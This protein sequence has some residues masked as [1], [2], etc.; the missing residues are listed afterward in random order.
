M[1]NILSSAL[2]T[3]AALTLATMLVACGGDGGGGTTCGVQSCQA[4]QYCLNLACV[5]GCQSNANC[6]SDQTCAL[7]D[8][9]PIGACKN[10]DETMMTEVITDPQCKTM[11]NKLVQCGLFTW[12]EGIAAQNI[13]TKLNSQQ[14]KTLSDCATAWDCSG[15][16]APVCLGA[17]C[18]GKYAC[19]PF[20][21]NPLR[22]VDHACVP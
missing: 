3:L 6:A 18:G 5:P 4:G 10:K 16:T 15:A 1:R 21:G 2:K 22:C 17:L 20:G 9:N 19:K 13:C 14:L 7:T 12:D 11:F 8:G